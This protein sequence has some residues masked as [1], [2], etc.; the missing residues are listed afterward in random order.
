MSRDPSTDGELEKFLEQET[1]TLSV[2]GALERS[3]TYRKDA[4]SDKRRQELGCSLRKFLSSRLE[5]YR[6]KPV[7][8]H[9]HVANIKCLA[10]ELSARHHAILDGGIFRIGVAQ[11]ALN[12]YLK[13]GWARGIILEPPHCPIDSTVLGNIKKCAGSAHCKTCADTTW[14]AISTPEE[15]LH[16]VEK[17]RDAG[18]PQGTKPCALGARDLGSSNILSLKRPWRAPDRS[19]E[20]AYGQE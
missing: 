14:T 13:Y 17:A 19:D 6:T 15:Y 10:S 4:A 18:Q 20:V 7:S 1:L 2:R 12:L 5:D 11:K 8:D 9:Q 3:G 16:F